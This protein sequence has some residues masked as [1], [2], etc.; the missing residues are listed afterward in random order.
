MIRINLLPIRA[1]QKKEMLI[2]QVVVLV[3]S[4]V[5]VSIACGLVHW[6]IGSKV[7]AEKARIEQTQAEI[8]NLR[9]KI[10]EVGRFKKLQKEL[11]GKLDVLNKLKE[12]KAGPVHLLD[13]LSTVLPEMVWLESFKETKGTIA[14]KG[15]G[16]NE[17]VVASFMKALEASPYYENVELKVIEQKKAKG[18]GKVHSFNLSCRAATPKKP[19]KK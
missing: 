4:I 12:A 14:I 3:L 6:T 2:A 5:L 17:E 10:G 15:V 16:L 9:K 19:E 11:Q 8:N 7:A 1:A 18:G 13:E